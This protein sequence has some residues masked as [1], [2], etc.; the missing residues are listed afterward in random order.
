M[1]A[2]P[3]NKGP[4]CVKHMKMHD[5]IEVSKELATRIGPIQSILGTEATRSDHL[6]EK[7][8]GICKTMRSAAGDKSPLNLLPYCMEVLPALCKVNYGL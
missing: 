3:C 4:V 5:V 1:D 6:F 8:Y 7:P 2:R